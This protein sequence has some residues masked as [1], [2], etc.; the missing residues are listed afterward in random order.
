MHEK[1]HNN[2]PSVFFLHEKKIVNSKEASG[3]VV[4]F[5]IVIHIQNFFNVISFM[6]FQNNNDDRHDGLSVRVRILKVR[7]TK[8][9]APS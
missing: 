9:Y 6:C 8:T 7:L 3:C 5:L 4:F 1:A 2:L